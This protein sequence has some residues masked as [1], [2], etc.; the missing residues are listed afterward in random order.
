M[1]NLTT[2]LTAS[3]LVSALALATTISAAQAGPVA[4]PAGSEKCY[5][6]SQAGK[7]DCAAGAHSCAG[8]GTRNSDKTAFVY[9]PAG[10][11]AKLVGGSTVASK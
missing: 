9:L 10:A 5:G 1:K 7:N 6:V 3:S 4:Q 11:C 2:T 8:Q